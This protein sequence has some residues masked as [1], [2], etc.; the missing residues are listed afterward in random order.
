MRNVVVDFPLVPVTATTLSAR[1]G[2][3]RIR[4]ERA[5]GG[6]LSFERK[7]QIAGPDSA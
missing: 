4:D 2:I 6:S 7:E 3:H 1:D 5:A